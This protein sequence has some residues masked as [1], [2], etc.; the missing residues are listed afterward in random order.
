[1]T[2]FKWLS[3]GAFGLIV[4]LA[5][6]IAYLNRDS[7]AVR[8][9]GRSAVIVGAAGVLITLLLSLKAEHV[10]VPP[11]PAAF[12]FHRQTRQPFSCDAIP[13]ATR[14]ADPGFA[15]N[16]R[17][18]F[19]LVAEAIKKQPTL[20][21]TADDSVSNALYLDV[22]LRHVVDLLS[23]AFSKSW[24]AEVVRFDLP[25]AR[26]TR[27]G[28]REPKKEG[29][30]VERQALVR[31]FPESPIL[32]SDFLKVLTLPPDT[33][34]R[35]V[36]ADGNTRSLELANP[37][38]TVTIML[39]WHSSGRGIGRLRDLCGLPMSGKY[40]EWLSATYLISLD[41]RFEQLRSGHPEMP[42]YR[43]W[44]Q[45]MFDE[46][47][48]FDA[49]RRWQEVKD[50]YQLYYAHRQETPL[51]QLMRETIEK[52]EKEGKKKPGE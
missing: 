48:A 7:E 17:P 26:E 46:L 39:K 6:W 2:L 5:G 1:M 50:A 31:L 18:A 38:A 36:P 21:E 30:K 11:F 24:D 35:R 33:T 43:R 51:Q 28:S 12:V 3:W 34:V 10:T 44:V 14:F 20:L 16:V 37:F 52:A 45:T 47:R 8:V 19:S 22:L 9:N 27:Y 40:D 4:I 32:D 49:E 41:A 15:G 23:F 42:V 29:T 25:H 13:E